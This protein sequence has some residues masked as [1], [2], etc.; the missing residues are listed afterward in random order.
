MP[1]FV[2]FTKPSAFS[3]FFFQII[4]F[5]WLFR[6]NLYVF[7]SKTFVFNGPNISFFC[8]KTPAEETIGGVFLYFLIR[9]S[10]STR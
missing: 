6:T 10:V 8:Y 5:L 9:Q 3:Q 1:I 7:L 4:R 2:N